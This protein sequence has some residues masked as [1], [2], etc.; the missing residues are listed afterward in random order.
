MAVAWML[1]VPQP[2]LAEEDP[3]PMRT[4][5][6]VRADLWRERLS[7]C[8]FGVGSNSVRGAARERCAR[9]WA[10][11]GSADHIPAHRTICIRNERTFAAE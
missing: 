6:D 3:T 11:H 5:R 1:R 9:I 4:L 10:H 8:A 2:H 7:A